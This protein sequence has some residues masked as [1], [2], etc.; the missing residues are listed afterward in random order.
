MTFC[1]SLLS[2]PQSVPHLPP[3]LPSQ[4][5]DAQNP[6]GFD[7]E[8]K[9]ESEWERGRSGGGAA[10]KHQIGDEGEAD[11]FAATATTRSDSLI[12]TAVN[13]I[14]R[15]ESKFGANLRSPSLLGG[16]HGHG[17]SHT[18]EERESGIFRERNKQTEKREREKKNVGLLIRILIVIG[19]IHVW[20][21]CYAAV[22][23]S[24]SP[25]STK[26]SSQRTPELARFLSSVRLRVSQSRQGPEEG[27]GRRGDGRGGREKSGGGEQ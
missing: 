2:L 12:A 24:S 1:S 5:S 6:P 26:P 23:F 4:D 22:P 25:L 14:I 17:H 10:A 13:A 16:R 18:T 9:T 20:T 8:D 7:S 21:K 15:A 11:R 27:E 19:L 3:A